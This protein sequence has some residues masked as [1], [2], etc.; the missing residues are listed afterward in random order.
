MKP[1]SDKA[2]ALAQK[3]VKVLH[4]SYSG[5]IGQS[6]WGTPE[7]A[8]A[9]RISERWSE[10][11]GQVKFKNCLRIAREEIVTEILSEAIDG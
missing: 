3:I 9:N 4:L 11:I 1:A 5:S 2:T 10:L 7:L 6:D 8:L